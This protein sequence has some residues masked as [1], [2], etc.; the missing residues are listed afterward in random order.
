[1]TLAGAHVRS[2]GVGVINGN[3]A[4]VAASTDTILVGTL[5]ATGQI[6][7]F[8]GVS[9]GL[10]R[11]FGD[12]GS[13]EGL[14]YGNEGIRFTPDGH[15]LVAERDNKRVSMF[16]LSGEFVRCIGTGDLFGPVDIDFAT[17]GAILVTDMDCLSICTISSRVRSPAIV[18]Q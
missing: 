15:I 4:S 9:G 2:I 6:L 1:M 7:M 12:K 11:S 14:L 3:V 8:D 16:T 18:R 5:S 10:I 13:E 17:S